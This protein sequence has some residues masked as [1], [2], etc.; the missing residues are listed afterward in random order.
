MLHFASDGYCRFVTRV[1]SLVILA[2]VFGLVASVRVN[3]QVVATYDFED[4]TAQGWTSFYNAT[5]PVATTAAAYSGSYSLLTSTAATGTGG[6]SINAER[7]AAG[8]G[9]VYDHGLRAADHRE[10]GRQCELH[11]S[12]SDPSCT[13]GTC[14]DTI[15][16][17]QVAVNDS[18]VGADRRGLH[19]EHDG[20]GLAAV[21]AAGGRHDAR[22]RSIWMMW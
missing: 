17:Y 10:S 9:E 5:T 12:R 6:P 16:S 15:G 14:Y 13:G 11:D 1:R 7:R 18:R 22:S 4:G 21:C 8:G 3:A 20:D 19:G 2:A